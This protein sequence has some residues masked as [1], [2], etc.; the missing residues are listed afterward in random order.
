MGR[1]A[2]VPPPMGPSSLPPLWRRFPLDNCSRDA[3]VKITLQVN[4]LDRRG[5]VGT[6]V[7]ELIVTES[8]GACQA[9]QWA[10]SVRV[11]KGK[12]GC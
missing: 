10:P 9:Q 8:P 7:S 12:Q 11:F 5:A 2:P 4:H 3:W 1:V 6:G